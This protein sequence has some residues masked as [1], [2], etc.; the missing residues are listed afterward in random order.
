MSKYLNLKTMNESDLISK[1]FSLYSNEPDSIMLTGGK[2][3]LIPSK[4][5]KEISP[6]EEVISIFGEKKLF[7]DTDKD[8]RFGVFAYGVVK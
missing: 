4:L 7:K 2:L 1:R 5:E 8:T 3:Y 6:D